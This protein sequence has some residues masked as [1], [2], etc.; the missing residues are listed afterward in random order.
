MTRRRPQPE[1]S[2]DE[3]RPSNIPQST[4]SEMTITEGFENEVTKVVITVPFSL[5][6][7]PKFEQIL[8]TH[9]LEMGITFSV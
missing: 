8:S 4:G 7:E 2:D 9:V 5:I 3:M 1:F 6:Q